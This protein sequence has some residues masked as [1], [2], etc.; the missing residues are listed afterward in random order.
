M[1]FEDYERMAR[2]VNEREAAYELEAFYA[3]TDR[4]VSC[5]GLSTADRNAARFYLRAVRGLRVASE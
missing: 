1:R 2:L 4:A 3:Q 5:A